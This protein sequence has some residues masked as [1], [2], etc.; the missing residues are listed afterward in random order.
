MGTE[1]LMPQNTPNLRCDKVTQGHRH[2]LDVFNGLFPGEA[3]KEVQT[4]E[5]K[6]PVLASAQAFSKSSWACALILR[7]IAKQS[8]NPE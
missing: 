2:L 1:G 5:S 7:H 6:F 8:L 4:E 3:G